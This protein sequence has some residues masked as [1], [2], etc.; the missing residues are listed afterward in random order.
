VLGGRAEP[1]PR[2]RLGERARSRSLRTAG[3]EGAA[4]VAGSV[5]A[6]RPA[7]SATEATR[8]ATG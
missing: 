5:P 6:I 4:A 3:A 2:F 8:S 1:E 7:A